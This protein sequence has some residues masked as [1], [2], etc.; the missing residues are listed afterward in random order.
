MDTTPRIQRSVGFLALGSWVILTALLVSAI[1]NGPYSLEMYHWLMLLISALGILGGTRWIT[2]SR[3][4]KPLLMSAALLYL[5]LMLV[6]FFVGS[7]W[8]QLEYGSL[9]EALSYA[10]YS[11]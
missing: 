9:S 5:M 2:S 4:W 1:V 6:R 11:H 8:W 3:G 7:V 10:L